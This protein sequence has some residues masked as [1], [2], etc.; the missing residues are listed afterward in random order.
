MYFKY[1][2]FTRGVL[3]LVVSHTLCSSHEKLSVSDRFLNYTHTGPYECQSLSSN[4][5]LSMTFYLT[6]PICRSLC[7]IVSLQQQLS[8]LPLMEPLVGVNFAHFV[9]YGGGQLDGES[10]LSGTF[11]SASLD[12]VSDYYSQLIYKVIK[13][14]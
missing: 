6:F 1:L 10:R 8:L 5:L 2:F 13:S 12:G 4:A 3:A 11:G 14:S 9:P 7:P